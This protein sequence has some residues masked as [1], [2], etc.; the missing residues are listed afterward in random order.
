MG[1]SCAPVGVLEEDE[2]EGNA[3]ET[4]KCEA[5]D[6]DRLCCEPARPSEPV[7]EEEARYGLAD[8]ATAADVL[9]PRGASCSPPLAAAASVCREEGTPP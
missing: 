9:G 1:W 2:A 7:A 4:E 5:P 6:A 8:S 3:G